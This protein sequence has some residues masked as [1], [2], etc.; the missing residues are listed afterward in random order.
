MEPN[1]AHQEPQEAQLMQQVDLNSAIALIDSFASN[2][3]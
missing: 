3:R 1:P 2:L